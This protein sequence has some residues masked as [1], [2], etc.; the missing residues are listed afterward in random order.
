MD[1]CL[2]CFNMQCIHL[3]DDQNSVFVETLKAIELSL[4]RG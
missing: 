4:K 3:Y 1:N 2:I